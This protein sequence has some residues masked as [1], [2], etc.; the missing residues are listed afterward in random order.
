MKKKIKVCEFTENCKHKI[1]ANIFQR[2]NRLIDLPRSINF[3]RK[4]LG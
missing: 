3:S 2:D 1:I 4:T